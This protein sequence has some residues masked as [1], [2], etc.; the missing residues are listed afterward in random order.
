[1]RFDG[2]VAIVT[3]GGT[4]IG[5]ATARGLASEGANVVVVGPEQ[6]PLEQVAQEIG[7]VA[8]VGD[9]AEAVDV[10]RAVTAAQ[11]I[12]GGSPP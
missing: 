11:E 12:G 4:G 6:E 2:K 7:G 1:M 5:A 9:A 8:I 3:G 10:R